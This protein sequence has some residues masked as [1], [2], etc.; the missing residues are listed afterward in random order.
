M[1]SQHFVDGNINFK[2]NTVMIKL[3]NSRNGFSKD[4][5]KNELKG[6]KRTIKYNK[7]LVHHVPLL[8]SYLSTSRKV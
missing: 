7:W 1:I 6:K 5:K 4:E 8:S 2:E 3:Y